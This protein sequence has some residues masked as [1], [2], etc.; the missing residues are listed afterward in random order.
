MP[1]SLRRTIGLLFAT[2]LRGPPQWLLQ[3]LLQWLHGR[4]WLSALLG[5]IG[6]AFSYWSAVRLGAGLGLG[7]AVMPPAADRAREA[8]RGPWLSPS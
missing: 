7:W 5:G 3:W 4:W 1:G 2:L 8:A 6:G